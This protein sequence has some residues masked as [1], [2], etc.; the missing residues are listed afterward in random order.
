MMN[1]TVFMYMPVTPYG[2]GIDLAREL[3]IKLIKSKIFS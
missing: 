2:L 1:E 3:H